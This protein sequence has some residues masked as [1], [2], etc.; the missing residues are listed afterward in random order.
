[1]R[2]LPAL[3]KRKTVPYVAHSFIFV[4]FSFPVPLLLPLP[5]PLPVL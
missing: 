1:M 2:Y 3:H 5:L 4:P